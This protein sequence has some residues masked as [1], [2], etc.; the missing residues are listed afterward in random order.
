ML[1]VRIGGLD[2]CW[3]C[4]FV[5]FL[6]KVSRALVRPRR[7]LNQVHGQGGEIERDV[8]MSWL[9]LEV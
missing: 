6:G 7:D 2:E 5:C 1:F 3:W 4:C 8:F 9:V